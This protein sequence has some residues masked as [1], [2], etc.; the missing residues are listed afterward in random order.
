MSKFGVSQPV[1][2]V[3]DARFVTGRGRYVD[4]IDVPGQLYGYVL[5]SPLAH[6]RIRALDT[7]AARAVPGVV[8]IIT[9]DEIEAAGGNHLNTLVPLENRDG[10]PAPLPRRPILCTD[11]VRHVGDHVAF[12]VA[13]SRTAARDAAERI[14]VDYEALE[15][16]ADPRTADAEGAAQVHTDVPRNVLFDWGFGDQTAVDAAIASAAHVTRLE[17]V[18]NR[19]VANPME[20]R[21]GL[22]EY[23]A[24][25][26]KVTL[27]TSTQGGWMLK[28]EL[29]RNVLKVEP[30]QVRIVTPDV[31]GGFGMKAMNYPEQAMLAWAAR[32]LGRPVKWTADRGESFLSDVQG[33]DHH[34]VAELAFDA[35]NRIVGLR[36]ATTANMGAYLSLFAPFIPTGA[37]LKVLPGVY[38]VK[39][40]YYH[41]KGVA[42]T[43]VPIDAY[44]G[45][46]RPEA[47]YLI[48]RLMDNAARELGVDRVEL[49]RINQIPESAMPFATAAGETYD[50]GD[51][52]RVLAAGVER[53]DWAG[54]A[55]R[56]E[57]SRKAGKLRGIGLS[58]YIESTMGEPSET[59]TIRF[60]GGGRVAIYVGT[61]SNGQG[62]ETVYRQF[63]HDSLGIPFEA[64]DVVQGDTDRIKAGGGTGGSRSVTAEGTAVLAASDEV[65]RRGRILAAG[66]LEAAPED[67]EFAAGQFRI[68]GTDRSIEILELAERARG[69]D[70]LPE[71]LAEGLDGDA[72]ITLDAW[73]FPNGCHVA[74]VEVDPG[75]GV[76]EVVRYTVTDDFGKVVNPLLLAGQIHGGVAQG[77]GQAFLEHAVYDEGGQL[78][79]G[80]FMDYCMPRADDMPDIDFDT[81]EIPCPKNPIG[82]KGAGEAGTVAAPAAVMNALVDALAER[83]VRHI[84]MPATPCRVWESLARV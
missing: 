4:D 44:R 68:A 6:A 30:D 57:A 73:T 79:S 84:D 54:F 53:A 47:I 81:I 33:R 25:T 74:E 15:P 27:T 82:M 18:N 72:T 36:V 58:Y 40:L 67:I 35:D 80:S 60:E 49:R 11:K 69:R 48:E 26:G 12:V 14:E 1:R 23:D 3:E 46:G 52:P 56:R 62:H 5:R 9:G 43:T 21:A 61:Q 66:E 65:I 76:A 55:A 24:A 37:A 8:D 41:V 83:G 32:K 77:L 13:E 19:V 31:G 22:A 71:E 51:F 63:V 7:S 64:I 10:K 34:T 75:T 28:D 2:R 70:D 17:L 29:A 42:T 59:A 45:A 39:C 20:P 38:D 50:S 78:L 16:V